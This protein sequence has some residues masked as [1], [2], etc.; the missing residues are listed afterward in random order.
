MS[1][2]D[3]QDDYN[4]KNAIEVACRDSLSPAIPTDK[5]MNCKPFTESDVA[6]VLHSSE[7]DNDGP[8]W[9]AVLRLA[10]GRFATLESSCDY[11]G[12]G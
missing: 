4:W 6:E 11:T 10:D 9:V 5:T 1:I 2:K 8:A 3:F 7:G 12:W